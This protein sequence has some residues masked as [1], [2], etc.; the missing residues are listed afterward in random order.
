[1]L[2]G[3]GATSPLAELEVDGVAGYRTLLVEPAAQG[4]ASGGH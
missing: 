3:D 1:V 2:D 4:R